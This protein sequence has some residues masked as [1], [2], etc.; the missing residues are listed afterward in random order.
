MSCPSG[1]GGPMK[2]W[3]DRTT[4]RSWR[5][6]G[7]DGWDEFRTQRLAD[8]LLHAVCEVDEVRRAGCAP[9]LRKQESHIQPV[10][11]M[12]E[13]ILMLDNRPLTVPPA[14]HPSQAA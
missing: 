9:E 11:R 4:G 8:S 14:G 1:F 13:R 6:G 3:L 10:E 7:I 12:I 2:E 5:C